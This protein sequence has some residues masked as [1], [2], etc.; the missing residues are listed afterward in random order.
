VEHKPD[1]ERHS[2]RAPTNSAPPPDLVDR[3]LRAIDRKRAH[4]H[5]L[6]AEDDEEFRALVE[7]ALVGAGYRVT[8]CADGVELADHLGSYVLTEATEDFDLIISDLRMP[9]ISGMQVLQGMSQ[10]R[11]FPPMILMTAFGDH[12][13]HVAAREFGAVATLDKPFEIDDLL[14]LVKSIVRRAGPEA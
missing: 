4:R 7:H 1:P 13:T 5:I 11:G 8:A 3:T 12:Q 2:G 14:A 10:W 6:L 9:G